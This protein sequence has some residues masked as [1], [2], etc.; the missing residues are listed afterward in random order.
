VTLSTGVA[1]DVSPEYLYL[2]RPMGA[3]GLTHQSRR[4]PVPYFDCVRSR[5]TP[6]G[7]ELPYR[8]SRSIDQEC[9]PL[10]WV[11]AS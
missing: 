3:D 2:V 5:V 6:S 9:S 11:L 7:E 8:E 4:L 1:T 10:T